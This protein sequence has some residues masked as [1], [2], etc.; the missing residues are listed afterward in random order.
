MYHTALLKLVRE[1]HDS[2]DH[3]LVAAYRANEPEVAQDA[4]PAAVLERVLRRLVR[5]WTKRFDVLSERLATYFAQAASERSDR[6]LAT[7]L[8]RGGMSIKFNMT[9]AQRDIIQATVNENVS[10]IKSIPSQYLG[11]VRGMV[12]RSVQTGRDLGTLRDDLLKRYQ[13]TKRRAGLIARDQNNKATSAM[14]RARQL[15]LGITEA[16]WVHSGGGKE[17][18]PTHVRNNGKRYNVTEGWYDP[19]EG[20]HIFPG[21]LINCRC[22]SRSILPGMRL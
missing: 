12:M 20:R 5:R 8:R 19:D 4:L 16:I 22:V 10:L 14:A 7:M 9:P 21:E 6:A 13:I 1:M 15:E 3:W 11:E 18:R 2:V 17:P